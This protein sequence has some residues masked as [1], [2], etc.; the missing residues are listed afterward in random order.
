MLFIVF[1]I[2]LYLNL[3]LRFLKIFSLCA[4]AILIPSNMAKFPLFMRFLSNFQV[5]EVFTVQP[6]W[7]LAI[8]PILPLLFYL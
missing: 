5:N 2:L 3:C 4:C 7:Y 6:D 8:V 1:H